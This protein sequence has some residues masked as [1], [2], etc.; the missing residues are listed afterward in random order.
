MHAAVLTLCLIAGAGMAWP[1]PAADGRNSISPVKQEFFN[2]G[3]FNAAHPD[4]YWRR[5]AIHELDRGRDDLARSYLRRAARF[6]DKASQAMLAEML[7]TGRGGEHD[8]PQ[9]YAW[10]DLAAE[11]GYT[12]FV[13]KR[14]EYWTALSNAEQDEAIRVGRDLY[15]EYADA[16][17]KERLDRKLVRAQ[18]MV[19]GSRV[20]AI[21][22]NLMVLLPDADGLSSGSA[23]RSG[24]LMNMGLRMMGTDY[25]APEYWQPN[26]YWAREDAVWRNPK[27]GVVTVQDPQA[28]DVDDPNDP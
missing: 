8:R 22:G 11:R 28:A 18:R 16:V 20:G 27:L 21:S 5:M 14:E 10:M 3:G 15:D 13:V 1:A 12:V 19:A 6:A 2:S 24:G 4:V 17:A 26:A 7:W 23:S 9:A 25:Y